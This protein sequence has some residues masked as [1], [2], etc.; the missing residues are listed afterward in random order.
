M[1]SIA[2]FLLAF[3]VCTAGC[4][5]PFLLT[6]KA[7]DFQTGFDSKWMDELAFL[8]FVILPVYSITTLADALVFNAIEFWTGNNPLD[9]GTDFSKKP[10][11]REVVRKGGEEAVLTY[12]TDSRIMVESKESTFILEKTPDGVLARGVDGTVMYRA[13]KDGDGKVS[14]YDEAGKLVRAFDERDKQALG[15]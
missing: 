7:F 8:S 11:T 15:I 14:V 1:R 3:V 2:V 9:S 10:G 6:R 4:T 12:L 5:G 13:E